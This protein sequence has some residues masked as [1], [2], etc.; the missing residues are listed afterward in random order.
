MRR[1]TIPQIRSNR[2]RIA[3]GTA[4]REWPCR[5]DPIG[6]TAPSLD[7]SR[8]IRV[9]LETL[10]S[11]TTDRRVFRRS[12]PG[13]QL[14]RDLWRRKRCLCHDFAPT[15]GIVFITDGRAICRSKYPDNVFDAPITFPA[16]GVFFR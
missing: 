13:P 9:G 8:C 2:R 12:V 1:A 10:A 15:A 4:R 16:S 14:V 7:E 11:Q 6:D 5:D 3:A